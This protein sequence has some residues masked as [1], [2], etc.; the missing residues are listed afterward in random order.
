MLNVAIENQNGWNYSASAPHK[1]GVG[2]ATPNVIRAHNRASAV[3]LRAKHGL[4]RIMVGRMGPLSGGPGSRMT[5]CCNPVR[6]TTH[7][8]ATS[9]GELINLSYEAAIMA[10][11]PAL[12]HPCVTIENG[13][14][15][16]TS[17]A[18]AE[19]FRKMHKDVLK[20]IDNL[21]CSTEFS[22][23]NFAPAEY[24]DEQGKKRPAYKITKNGFVFLVMGFTGKKAAAFKEAY[25]AEFDRM[26]NELRQNNT[27]PHD[28]II[29]GDGRTLVV[30]FD[31]HGNIKFTET[32]PEGAMFCT[33]DTFQFYL[34]QQGWTL[35]NRKKIKSMTVEQLLSLK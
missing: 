21:E 35:I 7:E 24:T 15:V 6:L 10:T 11:T 28:K 30:H 22:E 3:F 34:E 32:A 27:P 12:S 31:E 8:I 4:I 2:I 29:K 16:T 20:K 17:V 25:I 23:R 13:R 19:F 9:R 26:E 1:T 33:L 18:I 14:A 5:G